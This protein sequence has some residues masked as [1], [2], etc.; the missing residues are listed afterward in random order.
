MTLDVYRGRKTTMQ[1]QRPEPSNL[2]VS[3]LKRTM[4]LGLY[5]VEQNTGNISS[6]VISATNICTQI[7][8]II[9]YFD[10]LPIIF[11]DQCKFWHTVTFYFDLL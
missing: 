5:C 1:Q 8:V 6:S 2:D 9:T 3:S 11:A 7:F 4:N 10:L